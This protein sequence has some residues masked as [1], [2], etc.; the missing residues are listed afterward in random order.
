[1][2]SDSIL[3]FPK[4]LGIVVGIRTRN[5]KS[6]VSKSWAQEKIMPKKVSPLTDKEVRN[7]KP[8]PG[9]RIKALFDGG[10]LYLEVSDD[11]KRWRLKFR[12]EGKGK[13]LSLGTYPEVSLGE[14]RV[15][16]ESIRK[17][18]EAGIDPVE[19]KKAE[20]AAEVADRK[21][22]QARETETFGRAA[23]EW[24][25]A[26]KT[27]KAPSNVDKVWG[28]LQKDVLPWI[29]DLP[30]S[31]VRKHDIFNVCD[32]IQKREA[33]ETAHRVLGYLDAIFSAVIAND[34]KDKDI[35]EGRK[36]PCIAA[37]PCDDLRKRS[38]QLL[39]PAPAKRHFAHFRD[40]RTG[41]VSPAKLGEYL[42]AVDAFSGSLQVLAALKLAP[43]LFCRPGELRKAKWREIDWDTGTWS[44]TISKAKPG[45]QE[46]KLVV[47]LPRQALEILEDLCPFTEPQSEFIFMG[48]RDPKHPMSDAA[49]NAAIRRLGFDT[50]NEISGHGFRHVASTLLYEKSYSSDAVEKSL[51]HGKRGTRGVYD[52]AQY[53]EQRIPMYQAWADYLDKLK[54]GAEVI[55]LRA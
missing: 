11:V 13:L 19:E 40:E 41:G 54:A 49:V 43:M 4:F 31:G 21:A 36:L 17:K 14:A 12:A 8:E 28:R 35:E 52:H 47:P 26:W 30:V 53:L 9:K 33:I 51:G 5:G 25:D 18:L 39:Q 55:P 10:G 42:R 7:A 50:Q 29:G 37:N 46:R 34:T 23:M 27:D 16:R 3:L 20:K 45:E 32:R 22:E 44:F 2:Q 15:K 1:M 48:H 24:F 6:W 38:A